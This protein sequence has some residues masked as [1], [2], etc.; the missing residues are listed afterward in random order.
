[1]VIIRLAHRKDKYAVTFRFEMPLLYLSVYIKYIPS[2]AL[3]YVTST[4]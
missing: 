4:M 3:R 1:M 2:L